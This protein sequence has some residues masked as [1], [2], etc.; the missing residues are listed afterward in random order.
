MS[1]VNIS[2]Q[3]SVVLVRTIY[4]SNIGATARAMTNMGFSRLILIDPQCSVDFSAHQ[5]A[6]S[7]QEPLKTHTN[8]SSWD[9]FHQNEDPEGVR[10]SL[11]ARDGK[12]REVRDLEQTLLSVPRE[13]SDDSESSKII[14]LYLFF[15]PEDWGLAQADLEQTHFA[16]S[17]PIYGENTSLNLGQAVLLALFILRQTWGGSLTPLE[18]ANRK[19]RSN[20]DSI[21]PEESLKTWLQVLGMDISSPKTNAYLVLRRMLLHNVPTAKELVI[22]ETVVQQTIRKLKERPNR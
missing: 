11:T 8:Y 20:S 1:K 12:G 3:S 18:G 16:A 14:N 17:I 10:I 2:Y 4:S 21:F 22:L 9:E 7:G 19:I 13:N 5:A 6:A 15:G